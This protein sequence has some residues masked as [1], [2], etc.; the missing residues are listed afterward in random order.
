MNKK[1]ERRAHRLLCPDARDPAGM[2]SWLTHMAAKGFHFQENGEIF[3]WFVKGPPKSVRY[4]LDAISPLSPVPDRERCA[5]AEELGWRYIDEL[6]DF[7]VYL[8]EDPAAPELHTDPVT[9]GYTMDALAKKLRRDIVSSVGNFLF[10]GAML[11]L[12][13]LFHN[14]PVLS[15]VEHHGY[16]LSLAVFVLELF[17]LPASL[18]QTFHTLALRRRL[19]AGLPM[20]HNTDYR[21]KATLGKITL[22]FLFLLLI[23]YAYGGIRS[24]VS[25]PLWFVSEKHASP[26]SFSLAELEDP[27][28]PPPGYTYCVS[29]DWSFLAPTQCRTVEVATIPGRVGPDGGK[30]TPQLQMDYYKLAFPFLAG[31]LLEDLA[32]KENTLWHEVTQSGLDRVLASDDQ[33]FLL[34]QKGGQVLRVEY[35][36]TADLVA[37]LPELT[38]M[39]SREIK[40]NL[41]I[42]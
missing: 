15:L 17:L 18:V 21:R 28:G 34:L 29:C 42:D 31:P 6:G 39:L 41:Y 35:S 24:A 5:Q 19:R 3:V 14:T 36:G 25:S 37:V 33:R 30:Y 8:C 7:S 10:L 1:K 2:E 20:E 40:L 23:A 27:P 12:G 26:L 13:L 32:R 16:V 9:Q 11:Y 22:F 38:A 4:R